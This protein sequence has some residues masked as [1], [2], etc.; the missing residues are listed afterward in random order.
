MS[1]GPPAI[2]TTQLTKEYGDL[3]AIEDLDMR[4]ER[5]EVYGFLGPNGAGKTTTINVLF[6]FSHATSG[7][8]T[9]LGLDVH[10]QSQAIRERV[11]VL[12]EGAQLYPR[13]SGIEHVEFA[14]DIKG[15]DVDAAA[16]LDRVGLDDDDRRRRV[17]GY[18]KG[19]Q[20]R[21]GL[22]M[23]LVGDPELLVLD[24][25][26]SGL[27]PNGMAEMREI[28]REEAKRGTTVFFSSHLLEQ[29][30]AVC[31]RVG[32]L[33]EGQLVAEDTIDSLRDVADVNPVVEFECQET[34]GKIGLT[35]RERVL[36]VERD[37]NWLSVTCRESAD[38]IEVIR[39]V[40]EHVTITDVVAEE[41][42][43]EALFES[44]TS[45]S[46]SADGDALSDE[47]SAE[48]ASARAD[49]GRLLDTGGDR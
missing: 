21:L 27:D 6:D 19:M 26:S 35:D 28:I 13:L 33:N 47:Q 44:Y 15:V 30:E 29:V 1:A 14:A 10:E 20:Q 38:K 40:D 9:V 24:E 16:I 34:P 48:S 7:S 49:G 41:T 39:A 36:A 11:G 12:P 18:S 43:L 5:G 42:S 46:D 23:A 2:E 17:G 32:I 8:A 37:G 3:T 45:D 4:V 25:P 22:G 31:D